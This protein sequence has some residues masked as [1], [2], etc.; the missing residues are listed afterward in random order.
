MESFEE[1][2]HASEDVDE[3]VLTSMNG[4][5]H[6]KSLGITMAPR[7]GIKEGPHGEEDTDAHENNFCG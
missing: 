6:L 5:S 1:L 4:M 2:V 7:T 3:P